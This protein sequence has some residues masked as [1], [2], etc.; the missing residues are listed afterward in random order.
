MVMA[1]TRSVL[2]AS[3]PAAA[4]AR[5]GAAAGQRPAS[6]PTSR[7]NMFVTCFYGVLDPASGQLRYANAGHNLPFVRSAGERLGAARDRHAARPDAGHELRGARGDARARRQRAAL[8]RRPGRGARPDREMFG[9]R[10][11]GRRCLPP[12]RRP[13]DAD[14]P[15][16]LDRST[17]SP[18]TRASR[19]TTSRWSRS[20]ARRR[21]P[22]HACSPSSRSRARPATSARRCDRVARRSAACRPRAGAARAR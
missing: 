6:A 2:R 1:A 11:R 12:A 7:E 18:A 19:R 13:Q 14:R 5:R 17:A 4:R 3:R 15:L 10:P 21:R 16:L 8:Q 9:N 20:R 22:V